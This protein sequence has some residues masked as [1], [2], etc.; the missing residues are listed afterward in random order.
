M[1]A[2]IM[3]FQQTPRRA[4]LLGPYFEEQNKRV[5]L[6]HMGPWL[7]LV[8]PPAGSGEKPPLS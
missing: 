3:H 4:V 8:P 1:R 5:L 7:T 2:E 6:S